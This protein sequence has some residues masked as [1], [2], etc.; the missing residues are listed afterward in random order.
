[1]LSPWEWHVDDDEILQRLYEDVG[2]VHGVPEHLRECLPR[3]KQDFARAKSAT[4]LGLPEVAPILPHLLTWLQD[5][6]WPVSR[7]IAGFL[8]TVGEPLVEPIRHVLR[9]EDQLWKYWVLAMLVQEVSLLRRNLRSELLRI[10][11]VPLAGECEEGLPALASQIL[12]TSD[13]FA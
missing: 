11:D 13:E 2:G 5:G 3:H 7:P 4:D 10:A 6:N 1:M 8:V 9:S 12:R